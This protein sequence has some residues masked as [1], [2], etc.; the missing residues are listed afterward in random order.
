MCTCGVPAQLRASTASPCFPR[1]RLLV[2]YVSADKNRCAGRCA[3]HFRFAAG[4][5]LR[6]RPQPRPLLAPPKACAFG[7]SSTW[8][9][10]LR[11]QGPK[12]GNPIPSIAGAPRYGFTQGATSTHVPSRHPAGVSAADSLPCETYRPRRSMSCTR[13][14]DADRRWHSVRRGRTCHS[15]VR[16]QA[17]RARGQSAV[18]VGA[19][20]AGGREKHDETNG[21]L[22]RQRASTS[23]AA[24]RPQS[25]QVGEL[26][27]YPTH[28]PHSRVGSDA[29][30]PSTWVKEGRLVLSFILQA[31]APHIML[32]TWETCD[33][34]L[35]S[36]AVAGRRPAS[37]KPV[38]HGARTDGPPPAA[39]PTICAARGRATCCV[40]LQDPCRSPREPRAELGRSQCAGDTSLGRPR[41]DG[42]YPS[43][44][45]CTRAYD[46]QETRG[47]ARNPHLGGA[48]RTDVKRTRHVCPEACTSTCV[49]DT[50]VVAGFLPKDPG[51]AHGSSVRR[52]TCSRIRLGGMMLS[53]TDRSRHKPWCAS[54]IKPS[55]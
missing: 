29:T 43:A 39:P 49:R 25:M 15:A 34:R 55:V 21:Q 13:V 38:Q 4:R 54:D 36:M 50:A 23:I 8:R 22:R 44:R 37:R 16:V 53:T 33:D 32:P 14:C 6:H 41:L 12:L 5:G 1:K 51:R 52:A 18:A 2:E 19:R 24:W 40:G 10:L 28:K 27:T 47:D 35:C 46:L 11:T 9:V 3:P 30:K 17:P 31:G 48:E 26:C 45:L 7:R 20:L 42:A